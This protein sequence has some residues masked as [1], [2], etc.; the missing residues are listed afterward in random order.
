MI[1]ITDPDWE[2]VAD[3]SASGLDPQH[4]A[5]RDKEETEFFRVSLPSL[6]KT[7]LRLTL[8]L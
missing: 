8:E 3:P 6:L 5:R 7:Y 4:P 1:I 2:K